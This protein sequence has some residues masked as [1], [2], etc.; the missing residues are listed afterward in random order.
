MLEKLARLNAILLNSTKLPFD[1]K[2]FW[3]LES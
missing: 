2:Q 1:F 3:I